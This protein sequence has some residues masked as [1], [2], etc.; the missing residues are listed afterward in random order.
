MLRHSILS[1]SEGDGKMNMRTLAGTIS[2]ALAIVYSTAVGAVDYTAQEK[3][4][5]AIIR[6]FF[7]ALNAA[8]ARGDQATVI[9]SIAEK[10]MA[11]D[12]KQYGRTPRDRAAWAALFKG[13]S[14]APP[15]NA[16]PPGAGGPPAAGGSAGAG[17]PGA[18]PAGAGARGAPAGPLQPS[19]ELAVMADGDRV[20]HTA[21]RDGSIITYHLFRLK[22]G[23]IVEEW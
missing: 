16:G 13:N 4:N 12:F 11:K 14:G 3:A 19:R 21:T 20:G 5:I 17:A 6:G 9:D 18:G 2:M 10:Y 15:A 7:D 1:G 8:E 23:L 22:D